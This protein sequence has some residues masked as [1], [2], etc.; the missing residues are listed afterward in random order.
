MQLA[1]PFPFDTR[2]KTFDDVSKTDPNQ[3]LFWKW[4]HI[5]FSELIQ[6]LKVE[7]KSL[8]I[9]KATW[10]IGL[11]P[12][13][14]MRVFFGSAQVRVA[15]C[16]YLSRWM[17]I[18]KFYVPILQMYILGNSLI[19]QKCNVQSEDIHSKIYLAPTYDITYRTT[20]ELLEALRAVMKHNF[21]LSIETLVGGI[22]QHQVIKVNSG[23]PTFITDGKIYF[24][25]HVLS[26]NWYFNGYS[27]GL[28][29]LPKC[30][31]PTWKRSI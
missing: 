26:L 31:P 4:R 12:C 7:Q 1:V 29:G 18:V 16:T 13:C 20:W 10:T 6:H 30:S 14:D 27:I 8:P 23:C 28:R 2:H 3:L 11:Q 17:M 22:Y 9:M 21:T 24:I 15:T 5:Q 25:Q 19:V